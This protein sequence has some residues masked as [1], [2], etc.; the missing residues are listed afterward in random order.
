[1]VCKRHPH[2]PAGS[3]TSEAGYSLRTY[4]DLHREDPGELLDLRL[5]HKGLPLLEV[6]QEEA[7]GGPTRRRDLCRIWTEGGVVRSS[8]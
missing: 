6:V 1:M 8:E 7:I 5:A 2:R 4:T 3:V